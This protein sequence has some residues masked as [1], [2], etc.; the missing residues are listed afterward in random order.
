[1]E[2]REKNR[3]RR[4]RRQT[5]GKKLVTRETEEEKSMEKREYIKGVNEGE[6][7]HTDRQRKEGRS[8]IGK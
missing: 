7:K 3:S 6:E 2:I 4:K 8:S 1:M 5:E